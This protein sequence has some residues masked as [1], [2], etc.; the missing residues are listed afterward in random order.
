MRRLIAV[1]LLVAFPVSAK[2]TVINLEWNE[3]REMAGLIRFRP[4]VTVFMGKDGRERI[5]M[6][7]ERVS[8]SG[9]T[10]SRQARRTLVKREDVHSVRMSPRW[11][12]PLKWRLIA[13]AAAF[14]LWLV[15]LTVGL[16]I[17]GGIPEGRWHSNRHTGQGV[18]VGFGLPAAVYLLAQRADRR[19]GSIIVKLIEG[20]ENPK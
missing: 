17:P 2:P 7:L 18:I 3:L 13:A 4:K 5:R 20:K 9:I 10:L 12:N 11:G 16:G 19:G 8:A 1:F 15:G 14:P 6:N